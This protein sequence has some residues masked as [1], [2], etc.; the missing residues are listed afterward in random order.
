MFFELAIERKKMLELSFEDG[1]DAISL[2]VNGVTIFLKQG[3]DFSLGKFSS[4]LMSQ[5]LNYWCY[6]VT[7]NISLM[8]IPKPFPRPSKA[9]KPTENLFLSCLIDLNLGGVQRS[10]EEFLKFKEFFYLGFAAAVYQTLSYASSNSKNPQEAFREILNARNE[11][12]KGLENEGLER[13]IAIE[14][15]RP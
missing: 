10:M 3:K 9:I 14:V 11:I 4:E 13:G 15:Y 1:C 12:T 2:F 5:A 7:N 6:D 8:T